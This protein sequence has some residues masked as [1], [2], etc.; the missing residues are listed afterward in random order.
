MRLGFGDRGVEPEVPPS[1]P[2][3]HFLGVLLKLSILG[4]AAA[5]L[6]VLPGAALAED[7][8]FTLTNNSSYAVKSL[9]TSPA[10]VE[11]WEEDVFADKYLPAGNFVDVTIGDGR[12]Q[13]V[14]DMKFMLEDDSEFIEPAVDLCELGEYTL[15]DAT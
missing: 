6:L 14:Y 2:A 12:E 5:L 1:M 9:F 13:C 10:D 8:T 11:T 7:L 4:G 15:S 3:P